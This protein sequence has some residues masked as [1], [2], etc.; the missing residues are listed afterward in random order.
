MKST[1]NNRSTMRRW[2][3]VT[4]LTA[5]VLALAV[6][7]GPIVNSFRTDIDKFLGTSS[8]KLV[9]D[10]DEDISEVYT[11][12]SDYESTTELVKAIEDLGE[13]M[14]EEGSVLLKNNGALPLTADETQKVSL[15]GFSS[16]YPV[17]GGDMGSSL[18]PN[19]GTDADTVD[20]V[21]AL[22]AKGFKING[23]LQDLYKALE[24]QFTTEIDNWGNKSIF[25]RIT[26]PS[27][28]S[29]FSSKEPS[30]AIMDE[31]DA[32][33]KE[34][35]KEDNVII[36]TLARAAGE[37]RTYLPGTDGVDASQNLNQTDPLGLSDDERDL[38][39]AA[40]ESKKS[41][42]GKV[43]VLLNNASTMEID[44]LK[45]NDG[46]DAMLQIGL[47]G[48]YG[49]YGVADI[50]SGEANPS[51]HLTDT[52]AVVNANAP[53]AQNFGEFPYTNADPAYSINSVQ[54]EAE[55]I[56]IGYKYYETRYMDCVLGEGNASAA[57]G[58]ADGNAWNYDNEVSYPFGY[59]LS[60][61]T[62]EQ[63]LDSLDVDLENK[64]VTAK[65]TV[66]NTGD[67]AG[68]D[69][70]QLYVSTPYTSYD[71]EH[72][73]EKAGVQLLDYGKTDELEA[74]ASETVTIEADMQ[75]M[76][77]WD[78][79]SDNAAGTKGCYILDA[80]TYYFSLGNGAHE[81]ANNILSAQGKSTADGMTEAGD[82]A[83]TA[84][85][86]L[87][88]FD[89]ESFALTKNGTAV[90]NQLEDMDLNYWMPD[91]VTYMS[92]SDWA[93][94][95][96]KTYEN[97][98]ATDEMLAVLDNDTYEISADNGDASAV[99]FGAD[100]GLTLAHLKGVDDIDNPDY[101]KLL[102]QITLEECLIRTGFGGTSTKA[103]D[104]IH[105]PEAVQ[106]DGPN[107]I[108]SYP[109]G[110]YANTDAS[111][112]DPCAI[113]A[114]DKNAG[115]T[116]GVMGNETVIAQTFNK[117]LAKEFG[118]V[119]GNYSLWAN[120]PIY[121]GCGTNLHR[122]PYNARNHEYYSE[123]AVLTAYQGASFVEG[124]LEYGLLIAPKHLAFNDTEINRTGISVFMTEQQARE[125]ELR[126]TQAAIED[127]GALAVMTA[128]NRVGVYTDNSHTG[129]LINIL[130]GEWGFKGLMSEDFI[131]DANYVC[132]KEAV[133][134][135][136]TMSC[137][138]G[139]NT[140][141]AVSEKY[142]YWTVENVGKDAQLM[143][144]L[145][146]AMTYQAYA[147]ANS[148]A[149][150]G[151]TPTTHLVNVNT[152][153]DNLILGLQIAFALLTLLGIVMYARS[154]KKG[155]K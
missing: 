103:I 136:V 38:V 122:S 104:S 95:F 145:K 49:F 113:D 10:G 71:K 65:V 3:G 144:A 22:S 150:D 108:Y 96:P 14:N 48:G 115:Y 50:L 47:P 19:V 135:G 66:T 99:T 45:N 146:Q 138:T 59:G 73:I 13:R 39:A 102:D 152:W 117:D 79:S 5:S 93:G 105:S 70:V 123:D 63:K 98:T 137:N 4:T 100:N 69:V 83:L 141:A 52:Y 6:A 94:T 121:W 85:W 12:S 36:V 107:G 56:Y 155:D 75:Y 126:G 133:L 116:A 128:Y 18:T 24:P 109:L 7:A 62:F 20:F 26:A 89:N 154:A 44:E 119:M 61:T 17:M 68:K 64:T 148:N 97:L 131:M 130:R 88:A 58:S 90:E 1:K 151:Y 53:S 139:D 42:G 118:Q 33:W 74:G 54:V 60:Y 41:N 132:L 76:T 92:R 2:R 9:H 149:M 29:T 114:N 111:T 84:T 55:N 81:A 127:A 67:V 16:Y 57:V 31:T 21:Q 15:L 129:L 46:I 25:T 40:V 142:S 27:I 86:S 51:G 153:Y 147:L 23:N 143:A 72:G 80:G 125:N 34:N 134:N 110:Q 106:N 112:G 30:Q 101:A 35:L 82:T 28:G 11:Y 77:S 32:G 91:T 78:S 124:G 140:M 120:L 43:I 37:N 8:T 87:E